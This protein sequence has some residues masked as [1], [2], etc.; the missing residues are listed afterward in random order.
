MIELLT[1]ESIILESRRVRQLDK[2]YVFFLF[3]LSL[4]QVHR[5]QA[6]FA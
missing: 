5:T 6:G 1:Q 4:L 2:K 3:K